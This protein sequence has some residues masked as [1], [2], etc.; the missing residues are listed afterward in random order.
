MIRVGLVGYGFAG[1][2]FHSYLISRVPELQLAAVAT[3]SPE[4]RA[5]A[6]RDLGVPTFATIGDLLARGGV[7]LVVLA[8]PHDTH[9]SLAIEAMNAGKHVVTDKVM[10][11]S[12]ARGRRDDRGEPAQPACCSA[13]S[14][15]AAGTGTSS[16]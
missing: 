4:R 13:S 5:Q 8:T 12:T 14:R 3:R 6:E 9:A 10:C 16:P 15:T 7:D 2:G 1:R 11:L